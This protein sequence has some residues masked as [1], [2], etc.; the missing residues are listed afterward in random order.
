MPI[1]RSTAVFFAV[2]VVAAVAMSFDIS[3]GPTRELSG[4]V[5]ATAVEPRDTGPS[6]QVAT[7]ALSDGSIVPAAVRPPMLVNPGQTV[8]VREYRGIIS[9]GRTYEVSAVV[10]AK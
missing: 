8:Q 2:V 3:G 1:K 5:K 6:P 10:E 4:V 7:I 9:G